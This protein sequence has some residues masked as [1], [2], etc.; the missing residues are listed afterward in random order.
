M[1]ELEVGFSQH[2]SIQPDAPKELDTPEELQ[3]LPE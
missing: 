2:I 1:Q 3:T